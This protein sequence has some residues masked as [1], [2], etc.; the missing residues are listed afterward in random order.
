MY[1]TIYSEYLFST[2]ADSLLTPF[3]FFS[4]S[5]QLTANNQEFLSHS[6]IIPYL[7]PQFMRN[8]YGNT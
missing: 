2:P 8:L 3:S 7:R 1:C 6:V 5:C 4:F